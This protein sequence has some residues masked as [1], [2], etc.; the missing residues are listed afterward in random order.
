MR[1]TIDYFLYVVQSPEG[2]PAPV[3]EIVRG[4][5]FP[6]QTMLVI[7]PQNYPIFHQNRFFSISYGERTTPERTLVFGKDRL[8]MIERDAAI[9]QTEIPYEALVSVEIAVVLLYA[10]VLLRWMNGDTLESVKIEYNAVGEAYVRAEVQRIRLTRPRI[11]YV[12]INETDAILKAL[13]LKFR[14]YLRLSLLPSE[15]VGGVV[16]QPAIA[17]ARWTLHA[18]LSG[19]RLI[20]LTS[21]GITI[22]EEAFSQVPSYGIATRYFPLSSIEGI[23]FEPADKIT[24]IRLGLI[25]HDVHIPLS[26]ENIHLLIKMLPQ[27]L[28][29]IA[30]RLADIPQHLDN[31]Q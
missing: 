8:L 20:A 7:P 18:R 31:H 26:D 13:P 9:R 1:K 6:A 3:A 5:N 14:N 2:L 12:G 27:C 21:A 23:D 25:G 30:S 19:D 15:Q 11:E 4:A 22:V 16:F 29:S 10:Y 28:P 24:W 17:S